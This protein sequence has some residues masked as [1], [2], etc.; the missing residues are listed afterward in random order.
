LLNVFV[1]L[2][3]KRRFK[4]KKIIILDVIHGPDFYLKHDHSET[5]FCLLQ[6]GLAQLGPIYGASYFLRTAATTP[7][8]FIKP[9]ILVQCL[10][11]QGLY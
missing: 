4:Q 5:G 7:I 11:K 10:A 9:I 2:A 6:V 1:Q 8:G 3:N